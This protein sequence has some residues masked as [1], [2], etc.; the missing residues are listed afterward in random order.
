MTVQVTAVECYRTVL[1]RVPG[2][3]SQ[4]GGTRLAGVY[5]VSAG[6]FV[7]PGTHRGSRVAGP[8]RTPGC[9]P[10]PRLLLLGADRSAHSLRLRET[11]AASASS[12]VTSLA[13][14]ERAEVVVQR[15]EPAPAN[16][17]PAP[18]RAP[19]IASAARSRARRPVG[20]GQHVQRVDLEET[21]AARI[22]AQRPPASSSSVTASS[23]FP[24]PSSRRPV[25]SLMRVLTAASAT[26]P[27][28]SSSARPAAKRSCSPSAPGLL[29]EQL[30][31]LGVSVRLRRRRGGEPPLRPGRVAEV[32]QL[33]EQFLRDHPAKP[34]P[35]P[36]P[37][38]PGPP[39]S[40]TS[41]SAPADCCIIPAPYRPA[42]EDRAGT[43]W[44]PWARCPFRYCNN[45]GRDPRAGRRWPGTRRL[46]S[47]CN[48]PP[49][50]RIVTERV[51]NVMSCRNNP[52]EARPAV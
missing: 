12:E 9:P 35:A 3:K 37:F 21:Q 39:C 44:T 49:P 52:D 10:R 42:A 40:G 2:T 18:R 22:R 27:S 15:D 5:A 33:V 7:E 23:A 25:S 50:V 43:R 14:S 19:S 34:A 31:P 16:G 8:R 45:C 4:G 6:T 32:P 20:D 13:E 36:M 38:P 1:I 41:S 30:G 29:R 46:C 48:A 17:R 51:R 28:A 24:A 11:S 47:G 26:W